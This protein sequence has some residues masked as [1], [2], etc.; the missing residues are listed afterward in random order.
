MLICLSAALISDRR[1]CN[2]ELLNES[3]KAQT[4]HAY[5]TKT[6]RT[7]WNFSFIFPIMSKNFACLLPKSVFKNHP[8]EIITKTF[9][10]L[11][12]YSFCSGWG[13]WALWNN[14]HEI[15]ACSFLHLR[16]GPPTV[17]AYGVN[18]IHKS[19]EQT[20]VWMFLERTHA[21]SLHI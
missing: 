15:H 8:L 21:H 10:K 1:D 7:D 2:S 18:S 19:S 5:H 11:V 12:I 9:T 6:F 20:D 4:T 14:F 16:Q 3:I 13:K 17:T